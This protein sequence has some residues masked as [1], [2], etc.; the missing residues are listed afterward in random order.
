MNTVPLLPATGLNS[1]GLHFG[2]D[3]FNRVA[4]EVTRNLLA[5]FA[6]NLYAIADAKH[7]EQPLDVVVAQTN[8]SVRRR[9][10]NRFRCVCSVNSVSLLAQPDPAAPQ[11]IVF[12]AGDHGSRTVVGRVRHAVDDPEFS[13]RT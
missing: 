2:H 6:V 1:R 8:A 4:S 10:S 3:S 12:A 9:A 5:P 11:R 13:A 7:G